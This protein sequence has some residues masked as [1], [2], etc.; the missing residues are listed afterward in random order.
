MNTICIKSI[1][2]LLLLTIQAHAQKADLT[3]KFSKPASVFEESLPL[4]N[5]RLG[6]LV[7][8]ETGKERIALNEISLWSGGPQDGDRDS[9]YLYLK[10]IQQLLLAGKNK[11]AQE[12]LQKQFVAKDKGSALGSAANEKF[13]CYQ[14][15]G[16]LFIDWKDADKPVTAYNRYLDLE[17]AVSKT[18]Y[19]RNGATIQEE[20]ITDFVGN[21]TR[22]KLS[23]SAKSGLNFRLSLF[24][25]EHV[26]ITATG[27]EIM[28]EGQLPSGIDKG[29]R[30]VTIVVPRV[31]DGNIKQDANELIVENATECELLLNTETSYDNST[32]NLSNS[33]INRVCRQK[34]TNAIKQDYAKAYQAHV[35]RYQSFFNRCRFYLT[36]AQGV[37]TLTTNDRLI[38]YAGNQSDPA[39]MAL[40]FNFGRYLMISSSRP[41][42]L[43]ANLQGLWATEYQT[44]WNGD[45]HININVQMI[46]WPNEPAHLSDLNEPLFRFTK[47]L[48]PN[49]EKTAM[50]YYKANGWVAH[51]ICNPWFFTS[52]GEGAA[53]GSTITGGAWLC[54]QIWE[55]YLYTHDTVFLKQYYPV[56]KGAAQ[57]LQS[58]LIKEPKHGWL[59]T[60]P[61]NSPENAYIMPDG[62]TGQTCMGPTMDEQICRFIFGASAQ[63]AA[64]LNTDKDWRSTLNNIIPQ[65]APN[66][67][68][69]AGDINEWLDDWADAEPHHRHTSQLF[70]LH[71]YDEITPWETPAL[72]DAARKTLTQR[73]DGGTGWSKAWKI[74][75]WARLGDGDHALLLLKQLLSPVMM[76][77]KKTGGSGGTYPNLFCGH[78][79]FQIDGNFGGTAGIAEMLLQ[80]HGKNNVI[81]FLP[82]LPQ[83]KDWSKGSVKGMMARGGFETA[84]SWADGR[85]SKATIVNKNNS[86]TCYL[87]LPAGKQVTDEKGKMIIPAEKTGI[88]VNFKAE[89]N[90]IYT[91]R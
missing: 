35:A 49:G 58:V 81:R 46:Y 50:A 28:M 57:F 8:G 69:A 88:T 27:S 51:V 85:L 72:A 42:L 20:V 3:I 39:L 26:Q 84:F 91:I 32:G 90:K 7:Y 17:H 19:Q 53:W 83:N 56:M 48:M 12:L 4:G 80:S 18:Q 2:V 65:L 11:E 82:A 79:P 68:G 70:G 37:D 34:I 62:F 47:N 25:K 45:Y 38:R 54:L 13:G 23:S 66:Q 21:I 60:A 64:I 29:M 22:I 15:A 9:A 30:F 31:K 74:N 59:V 33:D 73:G 16:D 52:P 86:G 44:P 77:D 43:P 41:G 78:P 1:P 63:S 10:P 75:F 71:P 61:S 14:T 89:K 55:H 76:P 40:Y 5:G 87:L 24:R 6:A 67:I 36:P